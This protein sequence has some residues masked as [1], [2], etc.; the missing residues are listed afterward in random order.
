MSL[1]PCNNPEKSKNQY[2][3]VRQNTEINTGLELLKGE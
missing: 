1:G 2:I 3:C